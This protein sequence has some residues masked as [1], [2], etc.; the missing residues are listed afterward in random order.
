MRKKIFA[1]LI[2]ALQLLLVLVITV[3]SDPIKDKILESG[4]EYEFP[5]NSV[6]RSEQYYSY[7]DYEPEKYVISVGFDASSLKDNGDLSSSNNEGNY[8]YIEREYYSDENSDSAYI[9]YG[10]CSFDVSMDFSKKMDTLFENS[11]WVDEVNALHDNIFRFPGAE[12]RALTVKAKIEGEFIEF[13][14]LYID[15]IK[16]EDFF[17]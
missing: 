5:V 13:E 1:W 6:M 7:D 11:Y 10:H 8:I 12:E 15:G 17:A 2:L 14:G 9:R 16:A 4:K 3:F